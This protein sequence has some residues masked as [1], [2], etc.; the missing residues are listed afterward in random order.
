MVAL[1]LTSLGTAIAPWL[2][3][4]ATVAIAASIV[5]GISTQLKPQDIERALKLAVNAAEEQCKSLFFQCDPKVR[6][7]F[8]DNYFQKQILDELQKPL[9]DQAIDLNFLVF[10]FQEVAK[11]SKD[12]KNPINQDFIQPWLEVFKAEYI[13]AIGAYLKFQYA[14]T[15]YLKQLANCYDDVKF[16]GI[17]VKGQESDKSEKLAKIFVMQDIK[18]EKKNNPYIGLIT[19]KDL[20]IRKIGQLE[21]TIKKTLTLQLTEYYFGEKKE[22]SELPNQENRQAELLYQQRQSLN[23]ENYVGKAFTAKDL[24]TKNQSKK[25]ILLGSP[26]SGKTTLMSYFSVIIA[27]DK[28]ES[29]GLNPEIDWLPILIRMRD[30]VRQDNLSILEYYRQFCQNSLSI[31]SLPEGFFEHW[32]QDGRALILLDGLDEVVEEGKRYEIV[33]KIENFLGSYDQNRAIITSRPAG[34]RRDFFR[35]EEFPHYVLQPFDEPKINQFI[36]NWYDSR[37]QDQE[38][39][40]RRKEDIKKAFA[41]NPRIYH[42]AQNPLL[43]TI[44]TLIHRYQAQL[45]RE[46]YKLYQSAVETLLTTWDTTN[47]QLE[48]HHKLEYLNNDDWEDLIQNV[49]FW[50]HSHQDGIEG[51]E[52]EGTL[53]D[54]DELIKF[55]AT[56]IKETKGIDLSKAKKEAQRF[57][58]FVRDRSGLLNEQGTDCYAFVHKTFQ[59]YLCAQ[60][61]QRDMEEDSYDFEIIL[62]AIRTHLHD[63]HWREVLL[64]LVAQQKGKSA[65]KA[66]RVILENESEYEQWLHRDLLF[67]GSCLAENP[68]GLNTADNNLI[69]EILERL[70]N[71]EINQYQTSKLSQKLSEVFCSL[72]ETDFAPQCLAILKAQAIKINPER[73]F[74]Y[75]VELEEKAKIIDELVQQ[76]LDL[77]RNV[78]ERAALRFTYFN[79]I[80]NYV[81][82]TLLQIWSKEKYLLVYLQ[83]AEVLGNLEDIPEKVFKTWIDSYSTKDTFLRC[84]AIEALGCLHNPTD[85]VIDILIDALQ[86]END[87]VRETSAAELSQLELLKKVT[88]KEK[89]MNALVQALSDKN[90]MVRQR[91]I[92]AVGNLAGI[93]EEIVDKLLSVLLE[94]DL[95]FNWFALEA[96]NAFINNPNQS[97]NAIE[98]I[99]DFLDECVSNN[100]WNG[101]EEDI[102]ILLG[103]L[104]KRSKRAIDILVSLL[105]NKEYSILKQAIEQLGSLGNILD[106]ITLNKIIKTLRNL[107]SH[108]EHPIRVLVSIALVKL[109]DISSQTIDILLQAF[110]S[111][112]SSLQRNDVQSKIADTFGLLTNPSDQVIDALLEVLSTRLDKE[113]PL[114]G[115]ITNTLGKLGKTSNKVI[116]ALLKTL[117]NSNDFTTMQ[118]RLALVKLGRQSPQVLPLIMNWIE[119]NHNS[120]FV[121]NGIDVLWDLVTN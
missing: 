60:K 26:G 121:V 2:G 75:R 100:K 58:D 61:I 111:K 11:N 64:L 52:S 69:K 72:Y 31:T 5:K 98:R 71:L 3:E 117:S 1:T 88:I 77:D 23:S 27:Q 79:N 85:E 42:L 37:T 87:S 7:K 102:I 10:A 33:Q 28:A 99:V 17:N 66:I 107:L 20:N 34:Y 113:F 38:E 8:L 29:L 22:I 68:K 46:R 105:S 51:N 49:A 35:A 108:N 36:E 95:P 93:S 13:K 78:R 48:D 54:K 110:L 80:P 106:K 16:V 63:S 70:V 30:Y 40:K 15:N 62:E 65:A 97:R 74:I 9:K 53:I 91:A 119:E 19:E 39:A 55:L 43:L 94:N 84:K 86:D 44:I 90:N 4:W 112:D 12:E 81:I 115:N 67:A 116:E 59:E 45:P 32:L 82:D 47:K 18:E 101:T 14:K 83:I 92:T 96:L 73:L 6:Q 114:H 24:L 25:V 118:A 104:G 89:G 120:K 21:K 57:I 103:T 56:Y 76:L 109:G 50:I 41:K